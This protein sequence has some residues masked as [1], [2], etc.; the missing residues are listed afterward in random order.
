MKRQLLTWLIIIGIGVGVGV[1]YKVS[2]T[3]NLEKK[4]VLSAETQVSQK[5]PTPEVTPGIPKEISIPKI[6]VQS[7]IESVQ[8]DSEGRMDVPKDADNAAWFS[9]GYRPGKNGNAVLAG[10]YDKESGAPAIFWDVGKLE[11]DDRIIVTDEK[12]KKYTFAVERVAKYPYDQFPIKE[13][14]GSSS[15]PKLN[16]ITCHGDWNEDTKNYSQRM[17][18][19]ASLAEQ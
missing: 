10:H 2:H 5:A 1:G 13:V 17:V 19:Y 12:G 11:K 16:L 6:N 9:P 7:D 14:F 3:A 15:I 18:V 4:E 8:M